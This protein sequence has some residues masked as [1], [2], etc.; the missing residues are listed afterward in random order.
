MSAILKESA[1]RFQPM[2]ESDLDEVMGIE[3]SAYVYPWTRMIFSDCIR[4]GYCCWTG[5]QQ[6]VIQTYGVLS[7]A[8]GE[9][10]LLNLCVRPE[11]QNRGLGRKML[12]HMVELAR[13]H[14]SDII[15]LE[16]RV[17][18]KPAQALYSSMGFHELD[19]RRNY[20][21]TDNGREDALVLAKTL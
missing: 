1:L 14:G 21:P 9:S 13:R 5:L 8:A 6:G 20:Y 7:V 12:K 11:F 2:R 18:N 16:V 19:R 4:V 17:S 15:F 3:L 10:H